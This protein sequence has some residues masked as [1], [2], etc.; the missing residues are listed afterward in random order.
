[1]KR[2]TSQLPRKGIYDGV[3]GRLA[4]AV[5]AAVGLVAPRL[6]HEWR[7]ARVR[8]EAL[9]AF[10]AARISRLNPS[11]SSSSADGEILA[12]LPQLRAQCRQLVQ[13]DG[14]AASAIAILCEAIVGDGIRPQSVATAKGT[15][16]SDAELLAWR[17][18]CNAEW[19]RWAE[20]AD[21]TQFGTFYDLQDLAL[22]HLIVD[23]ECFGHTVMDRAGDVWAEL[24]D[25]D[26][27]ESPGRFDTATIRG[28]VELGER[29][30]RVAFHVLDHHPDDMLLY[31]AKGS[32]NPT[33]IAAKDGRFSMMQH[34]LRRQRAG[35]TRG[36]PWLAP[37]IEC[38]RHLHH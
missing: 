27:I 2:A 36:V 32:W 33:R 9:L 31:G 8:S 20:Q 30:E 35:Q 11:Q 29:G 7:R 18:A 25:P 14:H 3:R 17:E 10:E 19:A 5:D 23:G 26:R 22:R 24:L 15:G 13:N 1:M 6:A 21:A 28:G 38:L 12:D 16:L 4:K 34:G 37:G